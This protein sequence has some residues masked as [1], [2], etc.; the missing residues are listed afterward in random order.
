LTE[1]LLLA[2]IGGAFG[3]G[4]AFGAVKMFKAIAGHA[5]PRLDGATAGWAVLGWG[6]GAAVL[7]AF[8]AGV[9]PAMRAFR[10]DPMEVLKDAGP[11]GTAGVGERRL[12]QG[13]TMLQTALTLALLVGAGLL[14][15]TMVKIANI[16]SG[17]NTGRILTMSVTDVQGFSTGKAF[18][19]RRWS[20]LRQFQV[21]STRRLP[22]ACR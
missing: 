1:S 19:G 2:L 22:G 20:G 17:F 18:T 9:I 4:L 14:V 13:V 15:R 16:S 8:C 21:C 7:A 12:L 10:L 3:V 5:V 6:L 11:K